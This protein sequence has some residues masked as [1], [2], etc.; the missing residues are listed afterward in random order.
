M[1]ETS[2]PLA[3]CPVDTRV[4]LAEF[5]RHLCGYLD[6]VVSG[7]ETL[8]LD[9]HGRAVAEVRP[10]QQGLPL[11]RLPEVS[12]SLPHLGT[13][14]AEAFAR[15]LEEARESLSRQRPRTRGRIERR[16]C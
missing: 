1:Q 11:R 16:P 5:K 9:E 12:D 10:M 7:G 3:G 2:T 15:D 13:E 6:R 4:A 8:V 14:E